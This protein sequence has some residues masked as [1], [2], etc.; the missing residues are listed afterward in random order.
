MYLEIWGRPA[1]PLLGFSVN[2]KSPVKNL[3]KDYSESLLRDC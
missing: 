2:I 3:G 1:Q